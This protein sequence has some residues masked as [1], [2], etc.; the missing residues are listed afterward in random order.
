M[1][2]PLTAFTGADCS[3]VWATQS[4]VLWLY[5]ATMHRSTAAAFVIPLLVVLSAC[6]PQADRAL[7][8]CMTAVAE[9]LSISTTSLE[10]T[11]TIKTP[12]GAVDWRGTYPGGEWACGGTVDR[13]SMA[14][15][16]L[17]SG[18]VETAYLD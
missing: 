5:S 10:L 16:Y 13:L 18:E 17:D 1:L 7:E 8:Q 9:H 6:T 3:V 15:V 12:G 14:V 11:E 4:G 2:R